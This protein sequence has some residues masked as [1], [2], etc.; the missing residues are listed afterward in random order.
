MVGVEKPPKPSVRAFPHFGLVASS[1]E[2]VEGWKKRLDE[3][4]IK[5]QDLGNEIFFTDPNRVTFQVF[6][7]SWHGSP[8]ELEDLMRGNLSSWLTFR[9]PG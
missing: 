6:R 1:D 2:E 8:E 9:R 3:N 4:G 5:Y 7:K